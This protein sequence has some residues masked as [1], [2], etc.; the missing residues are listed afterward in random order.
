M[1]AS[2]HLIAFSTPFVA[3]EAAFV[4]NPTDRNR[5]CDTEA[6]RSVFL[7]I[8]FH[9]LL[10]SAF[11][12]SGLQAARRAQELLGPETWS[13]LV[14]IENTRIRNA[15]PKTLYAVVFEFA[16]ILWFYTESDG[17]QSFSLWA[18]R[19]NEEKANFR[20]GLRQIDPGFSK[21]SIVEDNGASPVLTGELP[22]GCFIESLVAG[23]ERL[24]QSNDI[25]Q[26]RLVMYYAND[27]V[28]GHCVLAYETGQG[29]FVLDP[30]RDKAPHRVG[31]HWPRDPVQI[32][33]AAWPEGSRRQIRQARELGFPLT[34]A[35]SSDRIRLAGLSAATS[36]HDSAVAGTPHR[37]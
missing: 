14:R 11:A 10:A 4:A 36:E 25:N 34:L 12:D 18:N 13:R 15:Y 29:I 17:T 33:R 5:T 37:G 1:C 32:A 16:G 7:Y 22:N 30:T 28:A 3:R 26:A 31:D 21:Y 24:A 35:R 8:L 27:R 9:F 2:G 20:E 6:V 23:R 19:L